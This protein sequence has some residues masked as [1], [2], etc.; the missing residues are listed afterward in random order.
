MKSMSTINPAIK[1]NTEFSIVKM[2]VSFINLKVGLSFVSLH[3]AYLQ[4]FKNVKQ[5]SKQRIP[6][7]APLLALHLLESCTKDVTCILQIVTNAT[8]EK[9]M[10]LKGEQR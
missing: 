7:E 2:C 1:E 4:L 8:V 9:G 5:H 10:K 6:K 3:F